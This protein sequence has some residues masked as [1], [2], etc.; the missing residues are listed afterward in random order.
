MLHLAEWHDSAERACGPSGR[1][2]WH[3]KG[4]LT[5]AAAGEAAA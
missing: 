2:R 4:R 1:F 5:G 3:R